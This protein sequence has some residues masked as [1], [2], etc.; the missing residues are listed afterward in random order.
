[1]KKMRPYPPFGVLQPVMSLPS[2]LIISS[3]GHLKVQRGRLRSVSSFEV[4]KLWKTDWVT[5]QRLLGMKEKQL[6]FRVPKSHITVVMVKNLTVRKK[7]GRGSF[8]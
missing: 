1:M 7:A 6:E 4:A 3:A 5:M 8:G 2:K